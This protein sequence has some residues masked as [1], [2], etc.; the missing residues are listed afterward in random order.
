MWTDLGGKEPTAVSLQQ[1]GQMWFPF[2][3][4]FLWLSSRDEKPIYFSLDGIANILTTAEK[5]NEFDNVAIMV[6]NCGGLNRIEQLQ[7]HRSE[8]IY[9]KA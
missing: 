3:R 8:T 4:L 5:L 6:E 7:H 2:N 1:P 9:R